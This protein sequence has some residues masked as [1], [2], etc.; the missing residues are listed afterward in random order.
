M[1]YARPL[2]ALTSDIDGARDLILAEINGDG[3]ADDRSACAENGDRHLGWRIVA[4]HPLFRRTA[5]A[6]QARALCDREPEPWTG[7]RDALFDK[8]CEREIHV[9]AAEQQ[10]IAD[11]DALE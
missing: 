3:L 1:K 9:V 10:V 6:A 8:R 11:R 2:P 7:R 5:D 4:E